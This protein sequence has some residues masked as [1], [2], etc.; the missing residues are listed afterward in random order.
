MSPEEEAEL[1]EIKKEVLFELGAGISPN[2]LLIRAIEL[3]YEKILARRK[4][5]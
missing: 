4:R 5:E 1:F 2:R 3:T